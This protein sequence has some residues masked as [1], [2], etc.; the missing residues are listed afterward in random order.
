MVLKNNNAFIDTKYKP[1]NTDIVAEF[2]VEPAKGYDFKYVVANLVAESSIG[3]WTEI[4]T[5][6]PYIKKLKPSAF[7]LNEKEK[8][9]RVA[10]PLE[11][12][13]LGNIPQ[14]LSS[15]AG[16]IYGMKMIKYLMLEDIQ[17]PKKY[18]KSF[19][20]PRF[21]IKG[22]RKV[23]GI[24]KRP[25]V[26]TIVK[27]KLGLKS[28]DH[29]KVAY[30]SWVGGIDLVKD[31]EN[32]T[33]QSFNK[34][35]KRLDLTMKMK[36]KAEKLTG[37]MKAYAI[38]IT[39]PYN[40]MKKRMKLVE[41][42]GNEYMMVDILTLGF[43]AMQ[44]ILEENRKLIVHG[45]RAMH[46]ALTHFN[47]H[48]MSMN[49]IADLSRLMGTD[50]LHIGTAVGKM[51]GKKAEV[52]SLQLE[53]EEQHIPANQKQHI[54][55]Q[56][57]YG[58][59]PV[60]AVAS[61]GLHPGHVPELFKIFGDEVIMQAGGGIHGHPKGTKAGATAMRQAVDASMEGISL[62]EYAKSHK[63]L[64]GALNKWVK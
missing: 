23:L 12:F 37:E 58:I 61:G 26:G 16:N 56:E 13:E 60:F 42:S 17:Y 48:G 35:N 54:L 25:I 28:V 31:D 5:E 3:T 19:K 40:E 33:S 55:S 9:C 15:I 53:I 14:L 4:S 8:I 18:V 20:G 1:S 43:S 41:R 29:A 6:K 2:R 64:Q 21:G 30:D 46:G 63:E 27:P 7:Y 59:K 38:N 44:S 51:E 47:K 11:L 22:V 62:K 36:R 52:K 24:K 57:W 49:V 10:Y 45:H 50:Q 32:L 34:F 39:A